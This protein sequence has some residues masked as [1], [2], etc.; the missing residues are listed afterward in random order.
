MLGLCLRLFHHS[1]RPCDNGVISK[2]DGSQLLQWAQSDWRVKLSSG[3]DWNIGSRCNDGAKRGNRIDQ[4]DLRT[5]YAKVRSRQ[6]GFSP[7][8]F[9]TPFFADPNLDLD[10]IA[11]ILNQGKILPRMFDL[12]LPSQRIVEGVLHTGSNREALAVAIVTL[13]RSP[14]VSHFTPCR[15]LVRH[16][17]GLVT[18]VVLQQAGDTRCP[19]IP[20][21]LLS[22][23]ELHLRIRIRSCGL[24]SRGG[25]IQQRV[26]RVQAGAVLAGHLQSFGERERNRS[27]L[28]RGCRGWR[29]R[30]S[31]RLRQGTS[32]RSRYLSHRRSQG[33]QKNDR[34][35]SLMHIGRNCNR[36]A[37]A[38]L[39]KY[40]DS[41][42]K[43]SHLV[44]FEALNCPLWCTIGAF[45][46]ILWGPRGLKKMEAGLH[47]DPADAY[48]VFVNRDGNSASASLGAAAGVRMG[49]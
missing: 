4:V 7:C 34:K 24:R 27:G 39:P 19:N 1:V 21:A 29:L 5:A 13:G 23:E 6:F 35:P 12:M 33:K 47:L 26:G 38:N 2:D 49:K 40:S 17:D 9:E 18:G 43:P 15:T 31:R 25:T 36:E 32:L 44:Q 28:F 42:E 8:Q 46:L 20:R 41:G 14:E 3:V 30:R 10:T 37:K 22:R 45:V 48:L 11:K 16:L